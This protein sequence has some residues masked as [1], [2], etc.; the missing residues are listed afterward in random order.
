MPAW[1]RWE[2]THGVLMDLSSLSPQSASQQMG[3]PWC[4]VVRPILA[5][6]WALGCVQLMA[7]TPNTAWENSEPSLA[8]CAVGK[9][10]LST[11][12]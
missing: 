6:L 1:P 10:H 9:G 8:A 3:N 5:Q 11:S 4:A 12:K 2:R 7:P